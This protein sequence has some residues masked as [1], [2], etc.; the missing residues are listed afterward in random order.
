MF[1]LLFSI[2]VLFADSSYSFMIC[3]KRPT[4]L[5]FISLNHNNGLVQKAHYAALCS[6]ANMYSLDVVFQNTLAALSHAH[7]INYFVL[8][9]MLSLGFYKHATA[10]MLDTRS[11]I[12]RGLKAKNFTI[13]S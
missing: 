12:H 8:N 1:L 6:I 2:I 9:L 4:N 10:I 11:T 7:S 5:E 3:A 13:T